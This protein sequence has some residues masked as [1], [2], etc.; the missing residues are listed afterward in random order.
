MS[1]TDSIPSAV[2]GVQNLQQD[3][4]AFEQ[5]ELQMLRDERRERAEQLRARFAG[6]DL[7]VGR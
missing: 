6:L 3:L 5:G 7:V 2:H 1:L 4:D